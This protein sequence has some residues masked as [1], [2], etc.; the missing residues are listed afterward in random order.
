MHVL[1]RC[2]GVFAVCLLYA[3]DQPLYVGVLEHPP[4]TSTR[5]HIRV[6]FQFVNGNW[7]AI[8]H[9]AA[10]VDALAAVQKFFPDHVS[11]TVALD[12]KKLG[13]VDS[14]SLEVRLYKDVGVHE[15]MPE[16]KVPTVRDTAKAFVTWMGASPYRPLV[17]I[18][19]PNYA[20]PDRWKPFRP[21]AALG[22]QARA[23]FRSAPEAP[24]SSY[25]DS[26]IYLQ[27]KGYRSSGG[28]SVIELRLRAAQAWFLVKNA[29]VYWIGNSLTLLDAGDYDGDGVSEL[30]FQKSRYNHDGYLLFHVRDQSKQ[31]FDWSYH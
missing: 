15:L 3:A 9:E 23:A 20:D 25:P 12:G 1:R 22:K 28:D 18:S 17:V 24:A 7:S 4:E 14:H 11:W 31:E 6:A 13:A 19:Q 29:V 27:P 16:S 8:P 21:A 30:L 2:C 10:D 5:P 26:D